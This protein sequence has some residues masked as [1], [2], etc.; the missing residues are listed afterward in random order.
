GIAHSFYGDPSLATMLAAVNAISDPDVIEVG[1]VLVIPN[2]S[3]TYTVVAGDA[4]SGIAQRFYGDTSQVTMLAAVNAISDPDVIE[5]GEVLVIPDI[6]HSYTVVAGDT[7]SGI[8]QRSYGYASL[9][10]LI[11]E[12]NNIA[13]PDTVNTGQVLI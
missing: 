4:L 9:Y 3:H 2:I 10:T 8:A 1:E 13:D 6:S 12:M 7:L 11:A 5:V